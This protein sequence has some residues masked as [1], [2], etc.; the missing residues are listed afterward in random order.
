[1]GIS[2]MVRACDKI[3]SVVKLMLWMAFGKSRNETHCKMQKRTMVYFQTQTVCGVLRYCRKA[4]DDVGSAQAIAAELGRLF[5]ARVA[6]VVSTRVRDYARREHA[7][8]LA[9]FGAGDAP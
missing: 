2:A 7:L 4:G 5:S 8:P 3:C 1:M 6:G 9:L